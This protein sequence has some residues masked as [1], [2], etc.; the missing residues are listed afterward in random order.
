MSLHKNEQPLVSICIPVYNSEKTIAS[1]LQS[2]LTQTYQ[3][4]EII[5]AENASTDHTLA[6]L[7]TFSDSRMK[8]YKNNKTIMGEKNFSRCIELATG[9]YIAIFHADDLYMPDMVQKQVNAFQ[10]NPSIGAV[11]TWANYINEVGGVIGEHKLPVEVKNKTIFDFSEILISILRN[12]NFLMCPSAMVRSEIYK[13]LAPFKDDPFG[14]SADLDMWLRILE[15]HTIAILNENLMSYRISK[16]QGCRLYNYLRTKE[17]DF[18][19]VMDFHLSKKNDDLKIPKSALNRYE[20]Q[21]TVDNITR[22]VNLILKSQP[23]EAKKLLAQSLSS[24][25]F[26]ATIDCIDEIKYLICCIFGLLLLFSINLRIGL[27]LAKIF[28][29]LRYLW[30]RTFV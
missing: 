13:E 7:E 9:D 5:I 19:K 22:S 20:L 11:F 8:I 30:K 15:K 27:Y 29:W 17:A 4:L 6:I 12:G 25:V 14:S 28:P 2:I 1:T 18:F 23:Q 10:E 21:R 24:R 16:T 26:M 3:N